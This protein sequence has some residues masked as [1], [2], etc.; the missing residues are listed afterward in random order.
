MLTTGQDSRGRYGPRISS[1]GEQTPTSPQGDVLASREAGP[2]AIRG[3]MVRTLGYGAG[4]LLSL[5]SAPLLLR[6]LGVEDFGKYITVL[7]LITIVGLVSD[8]GLTVVGVREYSVRDADGRRRLMSN[9]VT[10]RVTIT[11]AGL[12]FA[13]AFALVAGY[14]QAM[15][16]GT[17]VAGV[18]LLL[19]M[20]QQTYTVPLSSALR[21]GLVSGLDLLRQTLTV[22]G[23]VALVVA[24]AGLVGFLAIPVPVG[25][26]LVAATLLA[27]RGSSALRPEIDRDEV[28]YLLK[29]T[30]PAA[31]ASVL[32]SSFYRVAI[33]MMSLIATER[34]TG[35][36]SASFRVV[37][38]IIPI[39]SLIVG[40]A[41]PILARAASEDRERLAYA[42]QRLF[43]IGLILG[44]WVGLCAVLGA[45]PAIA[46]LGGDEFA[47]S[48]EVLRLQGI[49]LVASFLFPIWA[50]G[51]WVTRSLR[52]LI[53]VDLVGVTLAVVL[54]ALLAS[55]HGANGAAVA[56][57]ISEAVLVAGCGLA[58]MREPGLRAEFSVVPKVVLGT[59][60]GG[61]TWLLPIPDVV[62]VAIATLLYFGALAVTRAIPPDVWHSVREGNAMALLT[63]RRRGA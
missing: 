2:K 44:C 34:Q 53:A 40:A 38:V 37:E 26:A 57:T 60:A 23:I 49:A 27:V 18:G 45:G 31:T 12:V 25:L 32:A 61:A 4:L 51:L 8:A 54:T 13:T 20:V 10:L 24:G 35:F 3:G 33:V 21:L 56:M 29:E 15:V 46:F 14:E 22:V 36:F 11:V 41:F 28:R 7:S 55:S 47:P 43:E 5:A 6:H 58:L 62:K 19:T 52:R 17:L 42:L 48:A 1:A 9:L 39:P 16:I 63:A 50:A 59:V 30:L